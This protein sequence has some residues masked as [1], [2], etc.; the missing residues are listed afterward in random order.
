MFLPCSR[1]PREKPARRRHTVTVQVSR[2]GPGGAGRPGGRAA[3]RH[4]R[5]AAVKTSEASGPAGRRAGARCRL[6]VARRRWRHCRVGETH[7]PHAVY[8]GFHPPYKWLTSARV[9]VVQ[10]FAYYLVSCRDVAGEDP[11]PPALPAAAGQ[12]VDAG[13]AFV[14]LP[15]RRNPKWVLLRPRCRPGLAPRA[16][17]LL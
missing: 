3:R 16:S 10:H 5:T 2:R 17:A 11:V 8:G 7:R 4:L 1:T 6:Y 13:A 14:G 9:R 12:R 15:V